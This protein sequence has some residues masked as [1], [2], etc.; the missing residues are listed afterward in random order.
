M[1]ALL[2]AKNPG[3]TMADPAN[4]RLLYNKTC[5]QCHVLF[6]SGGKVG[7]DI[8][9]SNRRDVDYLLLH[10]IDPNA[11]IPNDYRASQ[12]DTKDDRTI[13]GIH[14]TALALAHEVA[15]HT[16]NHQHGEPLTA[17]EWRTEIT[18]C[19]ATLDETGIP[20]AGVIGFRAP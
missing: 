18:A 16:Q 19:A 8:T 9:G 4:G 5:G 11:V 20:A 14:H 3:F 17:A 1:K 12:L 7:P 10:V 15:N 2:D 6:D 13:I